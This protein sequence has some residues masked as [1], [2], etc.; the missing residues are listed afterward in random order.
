MLINY[1]HPPIFHPK[2][3][4]PNYLITCKEMR[5]IPFIILFKFTNNKFFK[6]GLQWEE[7]TNL[8]ESPVLYDRILPF[9]ISW[10]SSQEDFSQQRHV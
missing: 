10:L 2:L 8:F 3:C 4:K 6:I 5:I 9:H 7:L 1:F